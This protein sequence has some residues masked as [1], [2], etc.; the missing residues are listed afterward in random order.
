MPASAGSAPPLPSS[1][2]APTTAASSTPPPAMTKLAPSLVISDSPTT[3]RTPAE[4]RSSTL[5]VPPSDPN[6]LAPS[7]T[8]ATAA[9]SSSGN[10]AVSAA[11]GPSKAA[12]FA[13]RVASA[14]SSEGAASAGASGKGSM[15]VS[16]VGRRGKRDIS[17]QS[18]SNSRAP[19]RDASRSRAGG[20]GLEE[21]PKTRIPPVRRSVTEVAGGVPTLSSSLLP[22]HTVA[23]GLSVTL[24]GDEQDGHTSVSAHPLDDEAHNSDEEVEDQFGTL[25]QIRGAHVAERAPRGQVQAQEKAHEKRRRRHSFNVVRDAPEPWQNLS[26]WVPSQAW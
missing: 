10:I 4:S 7:P 22:P 24:A 20:L 11:A 18:A 17:S 26:R 2:T 6:P 3:Y 12:A 21:V 25:K 19:S 9:T 13:A 15:S 14:L 23:E 1:A 16:P 8:N 5:D